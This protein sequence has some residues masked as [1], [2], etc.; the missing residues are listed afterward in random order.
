M[1]ITP[2]IQNQWGLEL[3]EQEQVDADKAV[4]PPRPEPRSA[5]ISTPVLPQ[6]RQDDV[7]RSE[8]QGDNTIPHKPYSLSR[9]SIF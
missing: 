5:P 6:L 8:G 7:C 2:G 9:Q 3:D 4:T 1:D